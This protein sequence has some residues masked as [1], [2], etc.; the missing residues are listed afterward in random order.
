MNRTERGWAGHFC[1]S[2]DCLFRRNTLLTDDDRHIVVST[3]GAMRNRDGGIEQIAGDRWYE[4]FVFVGHQDGPYIEAA[5]DK[6]ISVP[7]KSLILADD[8]AALPHDASNVAN[9]MHER[10]VEWAVLNFDAAYASVP[11]KEET[12]WN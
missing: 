9:D 12:D 1:R 11:V 4:T 6:Q 10:V 5:V 7:I 8:W 3:V 2:Q